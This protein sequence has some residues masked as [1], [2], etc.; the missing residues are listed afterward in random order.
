[1]KLTKPQREMLRS[2]LQWERVSDQHGVAKP[3]YWPTDG[4]G[5][6]RVANAL[7]RRGLVETGVRSDGYMGARFTERGRRCAQGLDSRNAGGS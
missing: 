2:F 4:M 5:G 1:M 6:G 7:Q 3:M